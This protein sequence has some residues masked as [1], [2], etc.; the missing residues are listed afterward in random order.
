MQARNQCC[1]AGFVGEMGFSGKG[2][3]MHL[4]RP[5]TAHQ[6]IL[7]DGSKTFVCQDI[8]FNQTVQI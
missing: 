2:N 5:P 3:R 4:V 7:I 1:F 6:F 8:H